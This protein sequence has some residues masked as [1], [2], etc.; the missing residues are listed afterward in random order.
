[1]SQERNAGSSHTSFQPRK[2][3]SGSS[4][5]RASFSRR[6]VVRYT[7]PMRAMLRVVTSSTNT[8]GASSTM[9]PVRSGWRAANNRAIEAPSE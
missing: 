2:A 6:S 9:A 8:C 5:H 4:C 1:M 3:P 7:L